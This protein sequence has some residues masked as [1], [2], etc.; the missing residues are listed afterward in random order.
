MNF[1]AAPQL[2]L[3]RVQ[4]NVIE[5]PRGGAQQACTDEDFLTL[6][7]LANSDTVPEWYTPSE[8][9]SVGVVPCAPPI[10]SMDAL[11]NPQIVAGLDNST[12]NHNVVSHIWDFG[13][14]GNSCT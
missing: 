7:D 6:L 3:P 13:T 4:D 2:I 8:Y 12:S 1:C 10:D 5:M 11:S 9:Y 14:F